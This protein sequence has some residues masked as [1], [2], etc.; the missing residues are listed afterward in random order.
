M[1]WL[2]LGISFFL[3]LAHRLATLGIISHKLGNT[4]W[5]HTFH[6]TPSLRFLLRASA[7]SSRRKSSMRAPLLLPPWID[8][9]SSSTDGSWFLAVV[10]SLGSRDGDGGATAGAEDADSCTAALSSGARP[11]AARSELSKNR[12]RPSFS[13]PRGSTKFDAIVVVE[14]LCCMF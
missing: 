12:P 1:T 7:L 14:C 5:H 6:H 10:E 4:S 3:V 8:L 13:W 11:P 2:I 9:S